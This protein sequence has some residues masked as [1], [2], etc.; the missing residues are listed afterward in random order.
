MSR[1]K[2]AMKRLISAESGNYF[3]EC[4]HIRTNL[5]AGTNI[6]H[7]VCVLWTVDKG[8]IVSGR[9]FFADPEAM[10]AYFTAAAGTG[11]G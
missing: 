4:T 8:K 5:E 2:P 9:H 3:I 11:K 10:D 6:D 7:H 1:S